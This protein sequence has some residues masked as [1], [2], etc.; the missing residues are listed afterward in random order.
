VVATALTTCR[1]IVA[2]LIVL[3]LLEATLLSAVNCALNVVTAL[4]VL[5][6]C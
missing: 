5:E 4:V 1:T 6:L 2:A 3:L